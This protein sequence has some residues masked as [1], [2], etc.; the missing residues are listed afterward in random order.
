[1]SSPEITKIYSCTP[2]YI[3][4][5]LRKYKIGIR[6]KSEAKRLFYN[7]NI[8]KRDLKRW[9]LTNKISSP[10]IANKLKCSPGL[11]RNRLRE[12]KIPIRSLQEALLLSNTPKYPRH[13]FSDDLEEKAYLIG[14]RLGDLHV[15]QT[16]PRSIVVSMSSSKKAQHKL[17]KNLF[18]K[19]GHIW[20]GW[21]KAPDGTREITMCCYLDNTF[22]FLVKKKDLIE[23]WILRNKKYFA[24]FLAGYSDAEGSFC[25]CGGNGVVYVGSQDKTIIH[26]IREKLIELGILC[27]P[28]QIK[29]KKGTRDIRGTISNED[30]WG[31]W[32]HRKG[33]ILKLI[34]LINPYSKHTDKRKR[35][36]IVKN[37]ILERDKKYNRHQASKWDK[38]YLDEKIDYVGALAC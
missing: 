15:Y 4:Y 24:A 35:M 31:L 9:Y 26:Q 34:G 1:M 13:N 27:R 22:E 30:I 37:N 32:V 2:E 6:T 38:L 23:P 11:V 5:L 10:K 18:L 16:S 19:Y 7:I 17:F 28:P 29:R 33:S 3:R 21:T 14:F 12:Y 8:P 36:E 25:L 20:Q